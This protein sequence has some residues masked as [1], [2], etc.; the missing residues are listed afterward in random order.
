MRT[1]TLLEIY[2]QTTYRQILVQL[3]FTLYLIKQIKVSW[4]HSK[5]S[6]IATT[7]D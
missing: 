4:L 7:L 6:L 3:G 5:K 1:D 2:L